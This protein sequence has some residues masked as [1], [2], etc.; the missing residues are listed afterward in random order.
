MVDLVREKFKE[1]VE[2][3]FLRSK[4]G[5]MSLSEFMDRRENCL[6][7]NLKVSALRSQHSGE[8]LGLYR[9]YYISKAL[10]D[11]RRNLKTDE[12]RKLLDIILNAEVK[13][14]LGGARL[15]VLLEELLTNFMGRSDCQGF[16][17]RIGD[18]RDA[19]KLIQMHLSRGDRYEN[20]IKLINWKRFDTFLKAL[21]IRW[22]E[23][24][25]KLV[26]KSDIV[27]LLRNL[28]AHIGLTNF[29]VTDI[30]LVPRRMGDGS[31][32]DK[33]EVVVFYDEAL[34][35]KLEQLSEIGGQ[36]S[37]CDVR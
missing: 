15:G 30:T 25:P 24:A 28:V 20:L 34:F 7:S 14:D 16:T 31:D 5:G 22:N 3:K 37:L 32:Q 29:T 10:Y 33:A 19:G 23:D 12:D 11:L 26:G 4:D 27:A 1:Y 36:G 9:L 6:K 13:L 21:A 17:S 2:K 8:D 35:R 18:V